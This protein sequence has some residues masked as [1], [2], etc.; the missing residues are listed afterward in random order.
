MSTAFFIDEWTCTRYEGAALVRYLIAIAETN[1]RPG[2]VLIAHLC[3]GERV[4]L[5]VET[6]DGFRTDYDTDAAMAKA[7]RR[8]RHL[9][10][11]HET[12]ACLVRAEGGGE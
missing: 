3:D 6:L 10:L 9:A 1:V 2:D 8:H 4:T 12:G 5:D 7:K 11:V